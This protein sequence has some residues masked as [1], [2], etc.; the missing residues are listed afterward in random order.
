M[1]PPAP[2]PQES[3]LTT[4][5]TQV[6]Q[7]KA[8]SHDGRRALA[9]LCDVYY[10]PVVAFLRCELR[11][12]D[13]ARDLSHAFFEEMLAGGTI[14][15]ADREQGRFRSY[16]LGAVK[17]FLSHQREA[18]QRLKRGGGVVPVSLDE[19]A[20]A[21]HDIADP[22]QLPPDAAF[23]RQWA[24]TLLARALAALRQECTADGRA[25]FFDHVKPWLVGDATH[26]DQA[27]IG[28]ACGMS[29]AALKMAIHRLKRRF[30]GCVKA[31][32][33]ATLDDPAMVGAEMQVLFD[34]LA[35]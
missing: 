9:D 5:W 7:A 13:A 24:L 14:G 22:Q 35:G 11:D 1:T 32:I 6:R 27:A 3:F 2:R 17:H 16:L 25:H 15:T 20:S 12:A 33:A 10:E 21:A 26:G 4:R 19:D 18:A 29:P 28:E 23:D 34:A 31:E 30:R 8:D